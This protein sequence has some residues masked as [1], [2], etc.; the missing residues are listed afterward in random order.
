MHLPQIQMRSA[1]AKLGFE[2]IQG[3]QKIEQPLADMSIEQPQGRLTMETTRP[4]LSID[5]KQAWED[6]GLY[7]VLR[8]SE[9][10]AAEGL[11]SVDEGTERRAMEGTELMKIENAGNPTIDQAV[12]RSVPPMKQLGIQFIPSGGSVKIDFKP[13]D[14]Q[15]DYE[16]REPVIEFRRNNPVHEFTPGKVNMQIE[17]YAELDIDFIHLF[18]EQI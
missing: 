9:I 2:T 5:Q 12:N 14:L 4:Q 13:G 8:S 11:Q 7:G 15:M 17:Q 6:M 18:E 3:Q 1:F 16:R 10:A